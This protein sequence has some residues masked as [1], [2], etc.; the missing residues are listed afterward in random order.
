MEPQ[1]TRSEIQDWLIYWKNANMVAVD[2]IRCFE[3]VYQARKFCR[4]MRVGVFH[5]DL[6]SDLQIWNALVD[7]RRG[8]SGLTLT[9]E[10]L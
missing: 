8:G 5:T 1:M 3:N 2:E 6:V 10:Q 7:L 4:V 9:L